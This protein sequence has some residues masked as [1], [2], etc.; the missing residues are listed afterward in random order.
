MHVLYFN[1]S[2]IPYGICIIYKSIISEYLYFLM[3]IL[4]KELVYII[5]Y[6]LKYFYA[7]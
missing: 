6:C 4:L 2:T 3:H 5:L 1:F 7:L